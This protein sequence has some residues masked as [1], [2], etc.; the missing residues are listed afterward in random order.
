MESMT[1]LVRAIAGTAAIV[2]LAGLTACGGASGRSA[3]GELRV[4]ITVGPLGGWD[5]VGWT[6]D[7]YTVL[8]EAAYDSLL[9][10]GTEG[11]VPGLAESWGWEGPLKF[12]LSV[13]PNVKFADGAEL[14]A[15]VVK[16]NIERFQSSSNR[17]APRLASI[18]G[19]ET[20]G[21]LGVS[22]TLD[23]PQ[24]DLERLLSQAPGLM[25][26]PAAI[27]D[28]SIL[29]GAPA[30]IGPYT[31]DAS[32][33]T[34]DVRYAFQKNPD[35][36]NADT[37]GFESLVIDIQADR[38]ASFNALQAGQL[39]LVWGVA[40][41]VETAIASDLTVNELPGVPLLLA[42]LDSAGTTNPALGDLRVRQAMNFAIDREAIASSVL[43]G[44]PTSV[45]YSSQT[46][47]YDSRLEGVYGFDPDKAR[48]LLAAAGYADGL[49][50]T[51]TATPDLADVAS[52]VA[53]YFAEVG[54]E[55]GIETLPLQEYVNALVA[56]NLPMILGR[57]TSQSAAV[58]IQATTFPDG[59]RN[60]F[61]NS[62]DRVVELWEQAVAQEAVQRQQSF[63]NITRI[64]QEQ[65]W[66]VPVEEETFY[67]FSSPAIAGIYAPPGY[68]MPS[69]RLMQPAG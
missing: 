31:L 68:I 37:V 26:S 1:N 27:A 6:W 7:G 34:T 29:V 11:Y 41:N 52:A 50:L 59:G 51:L 66:F 60:P 54:I 4:A 19:I 57:A 16:A 21:D 22:F 2:M 30:G 3:D 67:Y 13:R 45:P 39:D 36:W 63:Q 24:P 56:G 20:D 48:S 62:I 10:S 12:N 18:T 55:L 28:P 47:A 61:A 49:A 32:Q 25:V 43:P 44:R 23:T 5:P 17:F 33:S 58:D 9:Q 8:E 53:A 46:E 40:E 15:D 35:Y 42:V 14:D 38:Q 69:L 64:V 65:A